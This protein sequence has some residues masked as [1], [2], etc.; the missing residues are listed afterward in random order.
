MNSYSRISLYLI[1]VIFSGRNGEAKVVVPWVP[2]SASE[3]L[4]K[5]PQPVGLESNGTTQTFLCRA[6]TTYTMIPGRLVIENGTALCKTSFNGGEVN[7]SE[8]EVSSKVKGII[9]ANMF[10]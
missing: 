9:D 4:L 3:A 2:A 1:F 10:N 7:H 8:F 6:F 5:T